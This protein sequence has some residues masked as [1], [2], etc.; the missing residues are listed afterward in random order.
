MEIPK[1]NVFLQKLKIAVTKVTLRLN[2]LLKYAFTN[3]HNALLQ[4]LE[5]ALEKSAI[6]EIYAS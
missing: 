4:K 3:C 1:V 2:K 5:C 6:P